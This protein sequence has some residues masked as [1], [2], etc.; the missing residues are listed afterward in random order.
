M[1]YLLILLAIVLLQSF[2]SFSY[3]Q[4]SKGGTPISFQNEFVKMNL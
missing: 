3:A 1:R 2:S 4:I